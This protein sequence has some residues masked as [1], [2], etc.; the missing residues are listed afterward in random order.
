[1]Y[2]IIQADYLLPLG[3]ARSPPLTNHQ[4]EDGRFLPHQP[5]HQTSPARPFLGTR[6]SGIASAEETAIVPSPQQGSTK[7][8]SKAPLGKTNLGKSFT[9]LLASS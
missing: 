6:A 1:V 4:D 7:R 5:Q 3:G 9:G 8:G 2:W